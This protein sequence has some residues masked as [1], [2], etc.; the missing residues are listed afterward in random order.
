MSD[1]STTP[2]MNSERVCSKTIQ[3]TA[4]AWS[5]VPTRLMPCPI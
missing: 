3:R 5:Q 1:A 4:A 2:S